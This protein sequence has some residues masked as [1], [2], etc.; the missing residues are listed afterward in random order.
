MLKIIV[1]K[2]E[3]IERALKRY[4]R[5]FNKTKMIREIRDR[6]EFTKPSMARRK[7]REKARYRNIY[8]QGQEE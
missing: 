7:T 4:K 2:D 1:K 8:L 5:K 3:S 6:K